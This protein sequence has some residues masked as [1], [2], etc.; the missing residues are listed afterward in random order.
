RLLR[1]A[2]AVDV[3]PRAYGLLATAFYRQGKPALAN[4][5]TAQAS[6]VGGNLKRAKQFAQRAKPA[7]KRGSVW[8][9]RMD[10]ILNT[11]S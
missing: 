1:S 6:F 11:K 4:A 7:L 5:A 3:N 9:V 2:L 8:W 10:D